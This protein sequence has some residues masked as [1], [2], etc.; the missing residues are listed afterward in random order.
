MAR[1]EASGKSGHKLVPG[2][3]LGL[4]HDNAGRTVGAVAVLRPLALPLVEFV[5]PGRKR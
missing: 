1:V 4:P 5:A 2:L 3:S